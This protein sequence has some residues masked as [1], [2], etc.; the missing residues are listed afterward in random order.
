MKIAITGGSSKTAEA[1]IRLFKSETDWE[2]HVFSSNAE[3]FKPIER[4]A[5]YDYS[6]L[7]KKEIRKELLRLEP[8]A[9]V[10]TAAMNDVDGCETNKSIAME[11]NSE[12]VENLAS[13]AKI[14]EAQFVT[15]STDFI[16][17]GE[18]GPYT[19]EAKPYP[20]SY[21]GK[22]KL[23]GENAARAAYPECVI[24]RTNVVYGLSSFGKN[25]FIKWIVSALEMDKQLKIITGQYCNP[26][27]TDDLA[28]ATMKIIEKKSRGIF[29]AAG[30]DWLNRFEIAELAA[31]VFGYDPNLI[32]PILPEELRQKAKRPERGGLVNLKAETN[33]DMKFSSMES[34]LQVLKRQMRNKSAFSLHK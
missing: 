18:N 25:D 5:V 32:V 10:N 17:D 15:F 2:L 31:E 34:G 12:A 24:V 6:V 27:L 23:S 19:E 7:A 26:T 20:I 13:V 1:M 8:D 22:S 4:V 3:D 16:F 9:I 14:C 28:L 33:L 30:A 11:L 21:Y 29:N